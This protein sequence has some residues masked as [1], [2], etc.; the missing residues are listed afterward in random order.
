MKRRKRR[1][2]AILLA[3]A[4]IFT[5]VDPSIFGGAITVHAEEK[6]SGFDGDTYYIANVQDFSYFVLNWA[7]DSEDGRKLRE[8]NFIKMTDNIQIGDSL[9]NEVHVGTSEYP[10]NITFDGGGYTITGLWDDGLVDVNNGLFGLMQNATVKNLIIKGADIRS[11]HYGG[12]LAAQAK[13]STIQNVTIIDSS[14]KIASMGNVVGLITTGGLYGGALVGYASNTKIYNCESRN[15][16]VY[17]DT[18]GGVQALG[19]DGMYMGGLVGWM[20]N[21][22]ILEYSRVVGGTVSTEYYVAVG[23]LAANMIYAGG[24]V[25]RIDGSDPT[26]TQVLDCFSSA[27]VNYDGQCY[28]SVGAG[29]S[30]Y[31]GGIA[32]RISGSNYKME[33]CHFAGNLSGYLLNS[34]LVL[35]II[36]MQDYYL[37]GVAGQVENLGGI[38]NCYFNWKNATKDND[39]PGGPKVPAVWGESNNGTMNAIGDAQYSNPTFFVNFDFDGTVM[40]ETENNEPFNV[41]H[42][43][44]WVIDPANNMPVHG[45]AVQAEIDFP[46]AGTISFAA[47]SIQGEQKTNGLSDGSSELANGTTI[48]QIAQT[49]AEMNEELT[50]TATVEPGYNFEGWY[51]RRDGV[52]RAIPVKQY[53]SQEENYKLVLG[54]DSESSYDYKDGDVFVAKYTANITFEDTDYPLEEYSYQQI[55]DLSKKIPTLNGYLFLEL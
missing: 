48:T 25:G 32:A 1:I 50:L 49:H 55:L 47:T 44:K 7:G 3:I 30:G 45:S 52:E 54:G 35:P 27:D 51:L 17:V 16:S 43:N 42:A 37:G 34:I 14:C 2:M 6:K 18:T 39:Y 46:G 19:G 22:S 28:V 33:R 26:T 23:A 8:V 38:Q 5:M 20:D 24:L 13:N 31:A 29:L 40:R 4:M 12:I 15:T 36:G 11:N 53:G 10:F 9:H 21:G 41:P